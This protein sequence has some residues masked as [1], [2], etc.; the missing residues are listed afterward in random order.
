M[1][2][3][4]LA[5]QLHYTTTCGGRFKMEAPFPTTIFLGVAFLE[6]LCKQI[7]YH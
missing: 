4:R 6:I 5:Q 3:H 7:V 2:K 1:G